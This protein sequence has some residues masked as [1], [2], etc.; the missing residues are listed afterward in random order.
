M[1]VRARFIAWGIVVLTVA[2]IPLTTLVVSQPHRGS[3]SIEDELSSPLAWMG[4]LAFS[5]VGALVVS[6]HPSHSVGWIFSISGL[7]AGISAVTTAYVQLGQLI[8]GSLPAALIVDA[9]SNFTFIVGFIAPTTL[10]LLLFPD[11]RLPSPRW[12]PVAYLAV[13]SLALQF[14]AALVGPSTVG[15]DLNVAGI[16]GSVATVAAAVFSLVAR[17]RSGS[18]ET[19]QQVKWVGAAGVIV[20]LDL[21]FIVAIV[22]IRPAFFVDAFLVFNVAYLAVPTAVGVAIL[23]Y[24]LY[25]IDVIINRAIVYV[26]L[27]ALLAGIYAGLV[28]LLQK[29]FLA[30]TGQ[31]SDAAIVVTVFLIATIFT[32]ARNSVQTFVDKRFKDARDLERLMK[33]LEDEVQSVVGVLSPPRLASRLL[34]D[35]A[36]GARSAA[37]LFLDRNG[38]EQ[39]TM[40]NGKWDGSAVLT[41]PLQAGARELGT[42]VLGPRLGGAPFSPR[43]KKRL[44]TTA[45]LVALALAMS[46]DPEIDGTPPRLPFQMTMTT[47]SRSHQ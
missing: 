6:R 10:G 44:Q 23:R 37:A 13:A 7:S 43:E 34:D 12:R 17:Y 4:V 3:I 30:A 22:L 2:C 36:E 32:P 38:S 11:G 26:S 24:R 47:D 45:D 27:S 42:L 15:Q 40:T 9:V 5:I 16:I 1:A 33:A 29:V 8:P 25:D 46:A 19:R 18:H 41:I 31:R 21:A 14:I 35:A 20:A 28:T 39:P